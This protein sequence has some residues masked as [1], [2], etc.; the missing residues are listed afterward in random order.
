[1]SRIVLF[2]VVLLAFSCG[3][4]SDN[5]STSTSPTNRD[6]PAPSK[7]VEP[8]VSKP[9][10]APPRDPRLTELFAAGAQCVWDKHGFTT[11]EAARKIEKL[12]FNHQS[13]KKLAAGCAE[14]LT[15]E[16]PSTRGLAASCLKS[17]NERAKTPFMAAGLDAY[18]AEKQPALKLAIACALSRN[19]AHAAGVHDRVIALVRSLAAEPNGDQPASCLFSSLFPSYLMVKSDTPS[20]AAGDLALEYTQKTGRLLQRALE[21]LPQMIDRK[22]EVCASLGKVAASAQWASAVQSMAKLGDACIAELNPVVEKMSEAMSEGKYNT[23]EYSATRV[24]LRRMTLSKSQLGKLKRAS[25]QLVAS[26]TGVW[27]K[28]AKEIA[29]SLANY[30]PPTSDK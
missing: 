1:M 27:E 19:N 25:K 4:G 29:T 26:A 2:S 22:P 16:K 20:K 5:E 9:P 12:A 30:K 3:K 10:P 24:L 13:D 6:Q 23:R 11:C 21:A 7:R 14:A 15:D 28:S 8:A 18:E 17:F